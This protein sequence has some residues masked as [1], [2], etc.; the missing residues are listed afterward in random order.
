MNN[1]YNLPDSIEDFSAYHKISW[2]KKSANDFKWIEKN[3]E[4]FDSYYEDITPEEQE[5]LYVNYMLANGFGAKVIESMKKRP[6]IS[7]INQEIIQQNESIKYYDIIR[8]ILIRMWGEQQKRELNAYAFDASSYNLNMRKKKRLSLHQDYVR[9][10]MIAPLEQQATMEVFA[11]YGVQNPTDLNP[12]QQQQVQ[13]EIDRLVKFKTPRDIER[14][15]RDEYKSHSESQLQKLVEWLKREYD[16]KFLVDEAYKDLTIAGFNVV[17]MDIKN[18]YP[19][20]KL[21]NPKEFNFFTSYDSP[22]I[23]DGD[24]WIKSEAVPVAKFVNEYLEDENDFN[25]LMEVLADTSGYGE[26]RRQVTGR[27]ADHK[28]RAI[29]GAIHSPMFMDKA[30]GEVDYGL[31]NAFMQENDIT[32]V[33]ADRFRY[34]DPI[35]RDNLHTVRVAR[36]VYS[37]F[38]KLQYVQRY[39]PKKDALDG[40]WVGENYQPNPD[41]DYKVTVKWA[42]ALYEGSK[43][44]YG[45]EFYFRKRR[46]PFQNRS[47]ND[48]FT[49]Y[50]PFEGVIYSRLHSNSPR[51][52]PVDH[53]KVHNAEYNILKHE[54]ET[55]DKTN[56]GNV[57][58]LP[59]KGLPDEFSHE[60]FFA[61]MKRARIA[62]ISIG[63]IEYLQATANLFKSVNLGHQ[64]DIVEKINRVQIVYQEC[65]QSMGY[66]P[67]LMGEAPASM[68]AT[69]NQQNIIQ[70]SYAMEDIVT[71]QQM[72]EQRVVQRFANMTRNALRDNEHLKTYLLD[73]LGIAELE[74]SPDVLEQSDIGI[75]I[76][77]DTESQKDLMGYK[78]LLQPGIQNG[79][80]TW[81]DV[82]RGRF[83]KSPS[84]II[85]SIAEG[86][87]RMERL[88]E[89]AQKAE[90]EAR[91]AEL[92]ARERER[93]MNEKLQVWDRE[94][95]ALQI[96]VDSV[97]MSNDVNKDDINDIIEK[98][99]K[100][101]ASKE[102]IAA[103]RNNVDL[104]IAAMKAEVDKEK[105]KQQKKTAST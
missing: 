60:Q 65:Q 31:I 78:E 17:E 13:S 83:A 62:P 16:L 8:S 82:I 89:E 98:T 74:L 76:V 58:L 3:C 43:V 44:G 39:N 14:F 86:E 27:L 5:R 97:K 9:Q 48:P 22:F 66:S 81:S 90:Q 52:A 30:T 37:S 26:K 42:K 59:D 18:N 61:V 45:G 32:K 50:S 54:I 84:V 67:A 96:E 4:Y 35:D 15:M 36:I 57:L 49:V 105:I 38:D 69:N 87:E 64:A 34:K 93:L 7:R 68:T 11:K 94:L 70:A 46:V 88:R 53:G 24:W 21:V 80:I 72:F 56:L 41:K 103:D 85:N 20:I 29:Q 47:L 23:G 104:E 73:D 92:E 51:V 33:I 101:N 12:E 40:F 63:E 79:L 99:D 95:K 2:E 28:I 1:Q 102:K 91:Q 75:T 19:W 100:D 25:K 77:N 71:L 55:L 10:T 6:R